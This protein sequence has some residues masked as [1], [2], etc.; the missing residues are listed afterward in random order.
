[1]DSNLEEEESA[2]RIIEDAIRNQSTCLSLASLDLQDIP[3]SIFLQV[4]QRA[5]LKILKLEYNDLIS[6]PDEIGQLTSLEE[7]HLT[8]N[9]LDSL[10]DTIGQLTNLKLS[11]LGGRHCS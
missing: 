10:P 7:V 11:L 1:M 8:G 6:L 3:A 4:Q 9:K 5:S 2:E